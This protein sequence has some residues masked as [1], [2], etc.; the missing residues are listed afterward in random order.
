MRQAR[1]ELALASTR[2][3]ALAE[4]YQ[5][6]VPRITA[7]SRDAIAHILSADA[8]AD[9][10]ILDAQTTAVTTFVEGVYTRLLVGDRAISSA[11]ELERFLHAIV[12]A[13]ASQP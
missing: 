8:S 13:V 1:H 3:P 7:M 4:V 10:D 2:D 9:S 11:E 6:F 5:D 12:T